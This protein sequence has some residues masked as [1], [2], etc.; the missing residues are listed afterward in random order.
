MPRS[1]LMVTSER[2]LNYSPIFFHSVHNTVLMKNMGLHVLV[3][4][5]MCFRQISILARLHRIVK[6]CVFMFQTEIVCY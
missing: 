5:I 1:S 2:I 3:I 4:R 6:T